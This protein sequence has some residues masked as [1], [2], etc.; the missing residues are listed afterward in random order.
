MKPL[1]VYIDPNNPR[2]SNTYPITN[3]ALI[4]TLPVIWCFTS[5]LFMPCKWDVRAYDI[6]H[7]MAGLDNALGLMGFG[8]AC[9]H[10]EVVQG[11]H[12]LKR[13]AV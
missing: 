5:L 10:C 6:G 12:I 7:L 13:F 11:D 2:A 8:H 9:G 3:L 4:H 1:A